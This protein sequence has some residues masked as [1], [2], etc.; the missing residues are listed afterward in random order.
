M[1]WDMDPDESSVTLY[2]IVSSIVEN[3]TACPFRSTCVIYSPYASIEE[4]LGS[5]VISP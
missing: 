2:G 5:L 3:A 1:L 4:D